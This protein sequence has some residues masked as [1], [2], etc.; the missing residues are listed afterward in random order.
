MDYDETNSK[1]K[2]RGRGRGSRGGTRGRGRGRGRGRTKKASRVISS[3]D[4]E[5]VGSPEATDKEVEGTVV[6]ASPSKGSLESDLPNPEP[7]LGKG[8]LIEDTVA[9]GSAPIVIDME[10]DISQLEAPTFTTISRGPPEPMLRLDWDHKV[11]LIGEKV[12][13]PMIYICDLCDKPIL[14][15]GRMIPCKHV[16]CL[17]CARSE[18]L[19]ICP[20]CKEKAIRVEQTGLGTVFMCTHGG[21]RYGSTGCRRT[22]LSQRDLQAHINHRHV[23]NPPQPVPPPQIPGSIQQTPQALETKST[24]VGKSPV[25]KN[26]CEQM[27]SPRTATGGQGP[28]SLSYATNNYGNSNA[29]NQLIHMSISPQTAHLSE[30]SNYSQQSSP[31]HVTSSSWGQ[32][33]QYYR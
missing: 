19:K 14:I 16:F 26:S 21:T 18:N 8:R 30:R 33:P 13:N 4:E 11:N 5:E 27:N 9:V 7:S 32:Q 15:Y 1:T 23:T 29:A 22:Y 6:T 20:R 12:L 2:G 24:I 25:R 3:D 28:I 31:R 17:K 10:A